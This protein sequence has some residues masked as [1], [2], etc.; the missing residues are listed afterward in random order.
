MSI[1]RSNKTWRERT[2][3]EF[4][5][6]SN[7]VSIFNDIDWKRKMK[8]AFRMPRR[9][10]TTRWN[11][12]MDIG[13]FRVLGRKKSGMEVL[14]TLTKENWILQS[15]K[16]CSDSK[17]LVILCSKVSV[18]SAVG[19]WS[20]RRVKK[21]IRFNGDSTNTEGINQLS[22][23]GAV[24]NWCHH[25]AWQR[26]K[27]TSQFICGQQD[28]DKCTTGRSTT[29]GISSDSGTWKQ[30]ARKRFELQAL[31]QN[32]VQ[33]LTSNI[34]W[35]PGSG[36]KFDLAGRRLRNYHSS[37]PGIHSFP[38]LFLDPKSWQLFPKAQ[39]LDQFW[40]F[41]LYRAFC[42]WNSWSQRRAQVQQRI[43]HS[44]KRIPK[45]QGNLCSQ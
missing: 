31:S 40:K 19:S 5:D 30:D 3:E 13:H 14:L 37:M 2:S 11:A 16:W 17:K 39:S 4:E 10:R 23:Y 7:F 29:L 43:A 36:T 32:F 8:I 33:K 38:Y 44:R 34:V 6:R 42:E 15:M 12:R 21:T 27:G 45:Q 9:S 28:F 20:R 24:V 25:S 1:P 41:E 35:Q 18:P 22:V 26:K